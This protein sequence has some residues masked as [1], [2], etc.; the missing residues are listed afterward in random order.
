MAGKHTWHIDDCVPGLIVAEDVYKGASLVIPKKVTMDYYLIE[1]LKA[2]GIETLAVHV[3]KGWETA[4]KTKLTT[5]VDTQDRFQQN[6]QDNV[7][8]MKNLLHDLAAGRELEYSKMEDVFETVYDEVVD[9]YSLIECINEVRHVDAYTYTHGLNVSLYGGLIARWMGLAEAEVLDVIQ[10]G[11]LHDIGKARIPSEILNKQGP[12]T[13][14]EM[15]IMKNHSLLGYKMVEKNDDLSEEIKETI[16]M[17]HERENGSGYPFGV[18]GECLNLYTKI[19]VVADVYDALTSERVYKKRVTPFDTF[20]ELE[21][22]GFE[23]FDPKVM[24]E[25]FRNIANYYTGAKVKMNTEEVGEIVCILPQSIS[26][27]MVVVGDKYLDLSTDTDY[28]IVEML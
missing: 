3:P 21:K 11:I 10:A 9:N 26:T 28:K 12:L 4:K 8:T 7:E 22:M 18:T 24:M 2:F 17:H 27:P 14:D 15:E 20:I 16:L 23:H 6:Y 13:A 25:F 5:T 19:I 1:R